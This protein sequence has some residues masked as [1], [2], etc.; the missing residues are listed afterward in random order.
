MYIYEDKECNEVISKNVRGGHFELLMRSGPDYDLV[1]RLNV[2]NHLYDAIV[3]SK[4]TFLMSM[5]S[6]L[7]PA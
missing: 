4:Y 1:Q 2:Q 5:S 3:N 7:S 6:L